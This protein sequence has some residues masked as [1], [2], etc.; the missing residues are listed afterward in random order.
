MRAYIVEDS[1]V[2]RDALVESLQE[3]VSAELV[4]FAES[5]A[6]AREWFRNNPGGW[7]V[8]IVDLF[9]KQGNGLGVIEATGN[10]NPWQKVVVLSNYATNDIR[11]RCS[12]LGADAVFDKSNELDLL[13]EYLLGATAVGTGGRG[14]SGF[15]QLT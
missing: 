7:D 9:L 8:A 3:L 12:R 10:R 13:F 11:E 14:N 15:S 1:Q 5:E 4:G 2:I 6:E